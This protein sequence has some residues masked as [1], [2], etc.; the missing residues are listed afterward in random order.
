MDFSTNYCGAY[1]SDGT[2]QASVA[3]GKST[4]VNALDAACQRHDRAYALAQN[5]T[6][7]DAADNKFYDTARKIGLKGLVYGNA[8]KHVNR[9]TRHT[10]PAWYNKIKDSFYK[11]QVHDAQLADKRASDRG[12]LNLRVVEPDGSNLPGS[13]AGSENMP[14][15]DAPKIYGPTDQLGS[16]ESGPQAWGFSSVSPMYSVHNWPKQKQANARNRVVPYKPLKSK[17]K[18]KKMTPAQKLECIQHIFPPRNKAPARTESL[19]TK[20]KKDG[21]A[22]RKPSP[23]QRPTG[24]SPNV[25]TR[26]KR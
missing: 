13:A 5:K 6:E 17:Q 1:W 22:Q 20:N 8:V 7:L 14:A 4:P 9:L 3:D 21:P 12:K 15:I 26:V 18:E 10:M 11:N 19:P 23:Q 2:F 16:T 24:S 25:R